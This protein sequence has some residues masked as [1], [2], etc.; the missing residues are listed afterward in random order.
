MIEATA[1][2]KLM[3]PMSAVPIRGDMPPFVMVFRI[4]LLKM[5]IEF[6]PV[7]SWKMMSTTLTQL[8]LRYLGSE[9]NASL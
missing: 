6:M 5:R 3:V 4:V 9:Q 2:R 7:S 1:A 8:A